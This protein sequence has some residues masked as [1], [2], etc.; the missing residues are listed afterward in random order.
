VRCGLIFI[1]TFLFIFH[2]VILFFIIIIIFLTSDSDSDWLHPQTTAPP[3]EPAAVDVVLSVVVVGLE[4]L[5]LG[6]SLGPSAVS[7][8]PNTH[9][10]TALSS[11]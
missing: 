8:M 9:L 11:L 2:I 4:T 3:L 5:L 10:G 6:L 1:F 7:F